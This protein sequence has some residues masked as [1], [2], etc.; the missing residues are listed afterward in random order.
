M[1]WNDAVTAIKAMLAASWTTTP[2]KQVNE[3][4]DAPDPNA[5]TQAWVLL[6]IKN[7]RTDNY[8]MGSPGN[9]LYLFEG[10]IILDVFVPVNTS[11][12][13][14]FAY[15]V[16]LGEIF[17]NQFFSNIRTWAPDPEGD[18]SN[19]ESGSWYRTSVTIPYQYHFFG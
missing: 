1:A 9:R 6:T 19:D 16:Q 17:R 3:P 7:D 12:D 14:A 11:T 8:T 15:A 5:A 2:I 13:T 18:G 10:R 4:F